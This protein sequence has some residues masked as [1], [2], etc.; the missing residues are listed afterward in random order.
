MKIRIY[1]FHQVKVKVGTRGQDD[2]RRLR[3]LRWILGRRM[4][5]RLDANE[6]WS[7]PEAVRLIARWHHRFDLDFV[8]APV[9]IQPFELMLDLRR[10]VS[11]ALCANAGLGSEAAAAFK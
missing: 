5:I 9:P 1:G 7:V 10:R 6:A 2:P 8:E 4:D 3:A 11:T